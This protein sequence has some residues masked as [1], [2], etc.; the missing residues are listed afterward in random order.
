M[1]WVQ[2]TARSLIMSDNEKPVGG[3][4]CSPTVRVLANK[5]NLQQKRPE[6]PTTAR[7]LDFD[8][9]PHETP[10][11]PQPRAPTPKTEPVTSPPPPGSGEDVAPPKPPRPGNPAQQAENTLKEAFPNID[12]SVVKAVLRASGGNVEPA[13]NALLGEFHMLN[14]REKRYLTHL[15]H[16]GSRRANRAHSATK[17][18]AAG[19]ISPEPKF[20]SAKPDGGR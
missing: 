12:A 16:V 1:K 6:S 14:E 17:A 11:S 20:D 15:R 5:R 18:T 10:A 2:L 13:F 3:S 19:S 8:D 7:E 4:N 9:E